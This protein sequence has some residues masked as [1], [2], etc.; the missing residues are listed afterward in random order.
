MFLE[1]VVFVLVGIGLT[2]LIVNS[3]ILEKPRNWLVRKIPFVGKLVSCMMCSGFWVGVGLAYYSG[4][5][6]LLYGGAL[7]SLLSYLWDNL[8][9][10]LTVLTDLKIHQIN[11]MELEEEVHHH[12]HHEHY[13]ED[14]DEYLEVDVDDDDEEEYEN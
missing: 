8:F 13:D 2:N 3:N 9:F 4:G 6:P 11:R 14:D 1:L 7:I 10:L 5:V 12:H